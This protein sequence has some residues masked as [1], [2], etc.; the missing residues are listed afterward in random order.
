MPSPY[1]HLLQELFFLL[2]AH[3]FLFLL[4]FDLVTGS[5]RHFR[6]L[7]LILDL[8]VLL[9]HPVGITLGLQVTGIHDPSFGAQLTNEFIVVRNDHDTAVEFFNGTSQGTEGFAV[10]VVGGLVKNN[11]VRLHPH[12]GGQNNLHLLSS[13]KGRH[14]VVS[15]E[16]AS[17]TAAFQVL[18]DV[19]GGQRLDNHTSTLGNFEIDSL[20]G[21]LPTHLLESLGRQVVA[22]VGGGS[23][24]TDFVL[25]F[26]RFVL[27]TSAH[28]FSDDL[29]VL[30]DLTAVG[31]HELNFKGL[32]LEFQFFFRELHG[33]LHERFLVLSVVGK[34]PSNVFV[35]GLV[36][37]AFDMVESVLGNVGDTSVG[38]LPDLSLLGFDLTDQELNHGRLSG[39]VFT[40]AGDTRG[41]RNLNGNVKESRL[42]VL[43]V[44][45]GGSGDL[46]QGLALGLDTFNRTRLGEFELALLVGLERE[47]GTGRRVDLDVFIEVTLV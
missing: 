47:V 13:G 2:L 35:G 4:D 20:H 8:G 36:Q 5:V 44:G 22:R 30:G 23:G 27:L 29:L 42:G 28:Q 37:V 34:A 25:V 3:L 41:Q 15:T 43:G 38:V 21:L 31:V 32:F 9:Q 10:Q 46:H 17:E 12:G 40:N 26:L 14:T 18:L 19:L 11:N 1:V 33:N 45:K 39:S 6:N 24:V 7:H 16:F